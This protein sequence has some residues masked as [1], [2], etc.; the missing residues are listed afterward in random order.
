MI[1]L[2]LRPVIELIMHE[3]K[4]YLQYPMDVDFDTIFNMVC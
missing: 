3:F 2:K 1:K 4:E